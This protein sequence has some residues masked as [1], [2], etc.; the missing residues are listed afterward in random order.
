MQIVCELPCYGAETFVVMLSKELEKLGVPITVLTMR[1][2]G[3]DL[4]AIPVLSAKRRGRSDVGF[5]FRMVRIIRQVKPSVVHTHG[6]HGKLWGRMAA[7][8]AGVKNVVHTEHNSD[9][10][11]GTLARLVNGILHKRTKVFV[12][13]S[14]TLAKRL[15]TED[16]VPKDRIA[17]IPNGVPEPARSRRTMPRV[18]PPIPEGA[19][20][21]LHVGRLMKVKNQQLAIRA[22]RQLVEL[23]PA[24]RFCLVLAGAGRDE[25]EL[26]HLADE[27]GVADR[28]RFL[29]YRNDV[30]D[31]MRR[32]NVL[33][34]TSLNEAMPMTLLQAMY[35]G[36]PV[37]TTPW[38]G[39]GELLESGRLGCITE[40][41]DPKSVGLA[42]ADRF[43][44]PEHTM[45]AAEAAHRAVR[46][47]F[48]IRLAARRHADLYAK[49]KADAS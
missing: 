39:A 36:V 41:Y 8:L 34:L 11:S 16:G 12:T 21:I 15:V 32:S 45:K 7:W 5:L 49:L 9:L 22:C 2:D 3:M 1:G 14:E 24:Q 43:D 37:V 44:H 6:Y 40:S 38:S 27:L 35:A 29:G 26:R 18:E 48:D 46:T 47:R 33:L 20:M 25:P 42:L 10:T 19:K 23:R 31:L 4:G 13:F 17:I 28:V 30:D